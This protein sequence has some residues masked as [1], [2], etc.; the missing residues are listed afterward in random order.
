MITFTQAQLMVLQT[1]LGKDALTSPDAMYK[2]LSAAL[3]DWSEYINKVGAFGLNLV[4]DELEKRL[5]AEL[6]RNIE[7]RGDDE[8][9]VAIAAGILELV[10]EAERQMNE[11]KVP[12]QFS[13]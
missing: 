4:L 9:Q 6:Q 2:V 10:R 7:G 8:A 1:G 11:K 13:K 12:A 5:L 3:P